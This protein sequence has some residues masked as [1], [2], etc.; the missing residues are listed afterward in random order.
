M[1][2]IVRIGQL[3]GG[4]FH[5]G[6]SWS[7]ALIGLLFLALVGVAVAA[8]VW[9]LVRASRPVHSAVPPV[10]AADPAMDIL[11]TRFARGEIDADEF[12]A[13]AAHLSGM[14][15][16]ASPPPPGPPGA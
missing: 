8:G 4:R 14:V 9:L 2:A 13:R 16:T 12:S 10:M 6:G 5:R 3:F 7:H 1:Y 15:P 11:R